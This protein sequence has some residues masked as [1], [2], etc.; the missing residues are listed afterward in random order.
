M[1][2][3][4]SIGNGGGWFLVALAPSSHAPGIAPNDF[5]PP[6]HRMLASAHP[7]LA[8]GLIFPVCA[9]PGATSLTDPAPFAYRRHSIP[10]HRTTRAFARAARTAMGM[11]CRVEDPVLTGALTEWMDSGGGYPGSGCGVG[12]GQAAWP[13]VRSVGFSTRRQSARS[14][15]RQDAGHRR[16]DS[17][18]GRK[19]WV[20]S[21]VRYVAHATSTMGAR[22]PGI[23]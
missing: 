1:V 11:Y 5:Y 8:A 17:G 6:R 10:A 7:S 2:R 20:Y 19:S 9:M 15:V 14:V 21:Q 13:V 4:G 18:R 22:L 16:F 12:I 3:R 23:P